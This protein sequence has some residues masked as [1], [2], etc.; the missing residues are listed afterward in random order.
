MIRFQAFGVQFTLPLLT[1]IA[2]ILAEKLGM[3]YG[4]GSLALALSVHELAHLAAAKLTGVAIQEIRILPIGGSARM[5]NPYR[6]PIHQILPVAAAGPAANLLLATFLAALAHWDLLDAVSAARMIQPNVI[7]F[8]F[9]LLPALPLDGGRMLFA[10]LC[11]PMG[12]KAALA[13]GLWSGRILAFLLFTA[14]LAGGLK[15]GIWNLSFMLA[16][17]FLLVSA[18]DEKHAHLKSRAQQLSD[19][20]SDNYNSK[21]ARLYQMDAADQVG[22]AVSL[23][24]PREPGWFILTRKGKPVGMLGSKELLTHLLNNGAPDA[25]LGDLLEFSFPRTQHT[26]A[27]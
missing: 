4:L 26:G 1:L 8:L 3:E 14:A 9:N 15:Q 7:L 10:L 27:Q 17:L 25:K 11:R 18:H 13:T 6:L 12:E 24:R 21:P 23:L 20:L 16:A 2:P 19:L 22:K 5:E